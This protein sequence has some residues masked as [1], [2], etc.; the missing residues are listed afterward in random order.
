VQHARGQAGQAAQAAR[1]VQ[2]ALQRGDALGPQFRAAR[3][4]GGERQQ[5]RAGTAAQHA[6]GALADVAATDD[7]RPVHAGSVRAKRREGSCEIRI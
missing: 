7:E 6:R 2:V 4:A 1:V 5:A 3:G